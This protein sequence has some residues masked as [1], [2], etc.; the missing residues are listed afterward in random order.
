MKTMPRSIQNIPRICE[1]VIAD[2][3]EENALHE[4]EDAERSRLREN[5]IGQPNIEV[6]FALQDGAVANDVVRTIR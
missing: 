6:A 1:D 2:Q 5:V 4:R 3:D